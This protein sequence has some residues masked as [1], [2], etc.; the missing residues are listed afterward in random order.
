MLL[1]LTT[2]YH[3]VMLQSGYAKNTN[4][5]NSNFN[6]TCNKPCNKDNAHQ[7]AKLN[8]IYDPHCQQVYYNMTHAKYFILKYIN[9][10]L[11]YKQIL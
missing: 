8:K 2:V 6:I 3:H 9:Q 10:Q 5:K 1:V 11:N 7:Q 4:V